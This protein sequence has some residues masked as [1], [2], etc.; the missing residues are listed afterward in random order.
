MI[1]QKSFKYATQETFL[2]SINVESSFLLLNMFAET[3]EHVEHFP[4]S[5]WY[6]IYSSTTSS[7]TT[8]KGSFQKVVSKT[9]VVIILYIHCWTI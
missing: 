4:F 6:I 3:L 8:D 7:F 5:M 1:H 2:I 9:T